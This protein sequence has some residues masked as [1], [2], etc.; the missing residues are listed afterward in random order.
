VERLFLACLF[1][2]L[3]AAGSAGGTTPFACRISA[4]TEAE[5][6]AYETLS[7]RLLGAVQER[8]E[9]KDGYAFRLPPKSLI[10]AA[11]WVSYERRCCP[12][13]DFELEVAKDGG[14]LWLRLTGSEGVK[15]F[16]RAEFGFEE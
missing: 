14:P 10:A 6:A 9:L 11:G 15:E 4:L 13:F 2:G 5:R 7:Q 16:I 1:C 12:F 3:I 8:R